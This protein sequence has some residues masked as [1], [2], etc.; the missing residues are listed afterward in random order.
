MGVSP[1]RC[2]RL[3][4]WPGRLATFSRTG[5]AF[6]LGRIVVLDAYARDRAAISRTSRNTDRVSYGL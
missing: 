1:S 5:D 2:A 3:T 6:R 4:P